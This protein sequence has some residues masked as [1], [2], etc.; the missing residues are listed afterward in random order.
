MAALDLRQRRGRVVHERVDARDD[1]VG[2]RRGAGALQGREEV[3]GDAPGEVR[4][5]YIGDLEGRRV[6]VARLAVVRSALRDLG[7][8]AGDVG[9]FEVAEDCV[10]PWWLMSVRVLEMWRGWLTDVLD[11]SYAA[12]AT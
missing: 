7:D 9:D 2:A 5:G 4:P 8:S 1:D 6:A 3:V 12:S 11:V 10:C